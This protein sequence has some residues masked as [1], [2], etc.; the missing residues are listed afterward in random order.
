M[1]GSDQPC[2]PYS[3]SS[4]WSAKYLPKPSCDSSG[5]GRGVVVRVMSIVL[6]AMDN[7]PGAPGPLSTNR[8]LQ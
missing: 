4:M 8:G 7:C 5:R 2:G 3:T 6:S 1:R